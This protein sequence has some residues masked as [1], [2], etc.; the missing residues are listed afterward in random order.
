[1]EVISLA[2][3]ARSQASD[4]QSK[5]V[6]GIKPSSTKTT[7]AKM[8]IDSRK[9]LEMGHLK[10]VEFEQDVPVYDRI[11]RMCRILQDLLQNHQPDTIVIETISDRAGVRHRGVAIGALWQTAEHWTS[12]NTYSKVVLIPEKEWTRGQSKPERIK[13]IRMCHPMY[14]KKYDKCS[15]P[16]GGVA[17]AVGIMEYYCNRHN[18]ANGKFGL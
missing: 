14:N 9:L 15:D 18:L 2:K 1:M 8:E 4:T 3:K 11:D 17:D 10:L 12:C 5:A 6:I 16:C 7:W 13:V